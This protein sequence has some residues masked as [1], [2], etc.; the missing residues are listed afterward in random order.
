M[1]AYV[2]RRH[3]KTERRTAWPG[4]ALSNNGD[5]MKKEKIIERL[6]RELRRS[7]VKEEQ[8][9]KNNSMLSHHRSMGYSEALRFAIKLIGE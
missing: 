1:R 6:E 2:G 4:S 7:E 9:K 3:L 8:L 5:N